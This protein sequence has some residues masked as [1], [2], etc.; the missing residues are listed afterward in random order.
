MKI[1]LYLILCPIILFI[2]CNEPKDVPVIYT[3]PS[4]TTIA[5]GWANITNS[6]A[7]TDTLD[8][9]PYTMIYISYQVD[10]DS[11][12]T[13]VHENHL[14]IDFLNPTNS[15]SYH[16]TFNYQR[17]NS[18]QYSFIIYSRDIGCPR[19]NAIIKIEYY[20]QPDTIIFSDLYVLGYIY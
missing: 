7:E 1:L 18:A 17:V 20:T 15:C 10:F 12:N 4:P 9:T 11:N 19:N 5:T 14:W 16:T 2:S 3:L 13:S 8:L 6:L